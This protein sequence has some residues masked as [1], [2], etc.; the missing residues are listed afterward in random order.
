[1]LLG[2]AALATVGLAAVG[3]LFSAMAVNTHMA[4]LLLPLLSLPFFLPIVAPA[5]RLSVAAL[6][7]L[8]LSDSP[9]ELKMLV[10][11]DIVF[12]TACTLAYPFTIEE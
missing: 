3:T 11:F 7:G 4:E 8:P 10:A 6:A 12:L 9:T 2:I 1:V 5:A